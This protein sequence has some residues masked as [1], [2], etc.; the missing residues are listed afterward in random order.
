MAFNLKRLQRSQ[1]LQ[2]SN[3]TGKAL[4]DKRKR[5]AEQKSLTSIA[6]P[7]K[8]DKA[9]SDAS[10]AGAFTLSDS[11]KKSYEQSVADS[12]NYKSPTELARDAERQRK[13][14]ERK[15]ERADAIAAGERTES[16]TLIGP[17]DDPY[18]VE[19]AD[20]QEDLFGERTITTS[21]EDQVNR[22]KEEQRKELKFAEGQSELANAIE[23]SDYNTMRKQTQSQVSGVTASF[24][25]GREGL[26]LS[27]IHI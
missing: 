1:D 11:S 15:Q 8:S 24:A 7:T 13:I 26:F 9:L 20:I 18:L 27:L 5:D 16:G 4:L 2:K 22:L 23:E 21:L 19:A 25:Q 10:K 17:D 12:K 6:D 3:L 14:D